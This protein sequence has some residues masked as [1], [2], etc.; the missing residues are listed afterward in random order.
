MGAVTNLKSQLGDIPGIETLNVTFGD[1]FQNITINGRT[2]QVGAEASIDEIRQALNVEKI[3]QVTTSTKPMSVTGAAHAGTSL[4]QMMQD[5][6]TKLAAAHDKL[7]AN[8]GKLD[9]ATAALDSLGDDVGS[10][11]DDLLASI[12][13]FKND[14]G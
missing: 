14:L 5:R 9:Q 3:N 11:A 8:M 6:K 7:N 12:G 1:G 10:E 2:I 13:Q 4:K